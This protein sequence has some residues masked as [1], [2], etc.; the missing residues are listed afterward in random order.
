MAEIQA[1]AAAEIKNAQAARVANC[2][3]LYGLLG[4]RSLTAQQVEA[5]RVSMN[6]HSCG[7][8]VP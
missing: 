1:Q 6:M 4:D 5:I 3:R 7:G 2:R 8:I